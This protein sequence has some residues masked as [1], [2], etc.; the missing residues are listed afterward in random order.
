MSQQQVPR[1]RKGKLVH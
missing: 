1:L